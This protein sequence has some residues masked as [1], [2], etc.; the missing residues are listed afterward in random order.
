MLECRLVFGLPVNHQSPIENSH[1]LPEYL[2]ASELETLVQRALSEDL[3]APHA[4]LGD[5]A[6]DVTTVAT[7]PEDTRAAAQ[8]RAKEAGVAAGL[9][10]SERVFRAADEGVDVTWAVTDGAAVDAGDTVGQLE[11]PA[12]G[13]LV[14]ERTALNVMQRMSGI[15]TATRRMV[16]RARPHGAEILDTRKTAPGL[17]FLDKWAV[18]LGG[19]TNHRLGL[20]DLILIKD[21]HLAAAGGVAEA[22]K[23]AHRYRRTHAGAEDLQVELETRT[24]AEV[25][26]ALDA[27]EDGSGPDI[28]LLDNMV[29]ATDDG[30]TDV[31]TLRE[32]VA[33]VDGR[34]R[35]EASGNVTLG[36]VEAIARTGVDAVSSGALTHSVR[37][38]DLSM[39]IRL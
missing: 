31:A 23:A 6:E 38:L 9:K 25:Q 5:G 21:N 10:A 28:V 2:P 37:A 30:E 18:A 29:R 26:A 11:G 36:T 33:L 20:H 12:R 22:L 8:I 7:V 13:L 24:L 3:V 19:G 17:R 4:G 32:A 34:F 15:A 14:A 39:E 35:T 1:V 27:E 16:R